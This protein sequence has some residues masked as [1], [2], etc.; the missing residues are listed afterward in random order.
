M[1]CEYQ[2]E[3]QLKCFDEK[4]CFVKGLFN[5]IYTLE[6][7]IKDLKEENENLIIELAGVDW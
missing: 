4:D 1:N 3:C 7:Q 6:K 5:Q 2:G